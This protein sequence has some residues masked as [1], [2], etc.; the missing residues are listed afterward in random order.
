[1]GELIPITRTDEGVHAVMGRDLHAFLEVKTRYNDWFP[2]M[3]EYGFEQGK[4]FYS[5][6]SKTPEQAGRPREDHIISLDMAKEIA[7]IQRTEKGRQARRYFIEVEKQFKAQAPAPLQGH[8]LIAAAL[9]EANGIIDNLTRERNQVEAQN[10]LLHAQVGVAQ[11][12]LEEQASE[13]APKAQAYDAFI[14]AEGTYSVGSVAK[15][16][17][18]SQN[19]LF[20]MLRNAGILIPKGHMR[21]TP[22][23]R[24]MKYFEVKAYAYQR[25][26]GT[27][28]VSYT[29]RVQPSGIDFI[30]TKLGLES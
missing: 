30:H 29:T 14:E 4:E 10:I 25:G 1:M 19:K 26:N 23:Q 15:M 16:F 28:G 6:L 21:N 18:L 22:Y 13:L 9:I 3:L 5:F 11:K 12:Q 17:G 20:Q 7:M 27:D 8:E 24:Y 2:R